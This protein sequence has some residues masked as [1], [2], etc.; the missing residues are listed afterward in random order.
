M[1][2]ILDFDGTVTVND[3]VDVLAAFAVSFQQKRQRERQQQSQQQLS[4]RAPTSDVDWDACWKAIV[5]NYLAEH[6]NHKATYELPEHA[7]TTVAHELEYLRSLRDVD[8]RSIRALR[9]AGLFA[10]LTPPPELLVEAG[11]NAVVTV[12]S[13]TSRT[14][15]AEAE[16]EPEV[17]TKTTKNAVAPQ[18]PGRVDVVRLRSGFS[19]FLDE[20]IHH[21][22]WV[23]SVVS[24]NWSD[25]WIRGVIG[26]CNGTAEGPD[27]CVFANKI[28]PSGAIV[29]NFRRHRRAQNRPIDEGHKDMTDEKNISRDGADDS[30]HGDGAEEKREEEYDDY[31]YG[32]DDDDDDEDNNV[33]V[34][35]CSDKLDT[36]E[37]ATQAAASFREEVEDHGPEPVIY[38]GD[39]TT[40]LE[41]L[42]YVAKSGVHGSGGIVLADGDGPVTSKLLQTLAR[43]GYAVPHVSKADPFKTA[44]RSRYPARHPRLAWARDFD[45]ILASK[46]LD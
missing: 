10:G 25:A 13:D 4:P 7:R 32:G 34:A 3:T 24:I 1:H 38:M 11:R 46:I 37:A 19:D 15:E 44:Q 39:S 6:R 17:E 35:S 27:I 22:K 30:D 26:S 33:P 23:V 21:R 41:C 18:P 9:D 2:V 43:L 14:T 31:G 28:T 16:E 45:E 12:A 40:D 42:L 5:D 36:L 29:P 8:R 20:V